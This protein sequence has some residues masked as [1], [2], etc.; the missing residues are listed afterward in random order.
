MPQS[1]T[2]ACELRFPHDSLR[3]SSLTNKH[4]CGIFHSQTSVSVTASSTEACRGPFPVD[5]SLGSS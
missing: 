2:V 1:L 5:E 4:K 3:F